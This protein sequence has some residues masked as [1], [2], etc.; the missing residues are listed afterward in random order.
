M[1]TNMLW[2]LMVLAVSLTCAAEDGYWVGRV[3]D[4][5]IS[6]DDLKEVGAEQIRNAHCRWMM[7]SSYFPHGVLDGGGEIYVAPAPIDDQGART[8]SRNTDNRIA[9]R[10]ED[11]SEVTG[12]VFVTRFNTTGMVAL[13]FRATLKSGDDAK[14]KVR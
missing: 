10:V 1:K 13:R 6:E 14:R 8:I 2:L 12:R 4:L 3:N 5:T 9:I 11:G 7:R